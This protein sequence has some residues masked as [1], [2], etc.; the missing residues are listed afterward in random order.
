M[1]KRTKDKN[2]SAEEPKRYGLR[3]RTF[4]KSLINIEGDSVGKK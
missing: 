4:I 1:M 3:F 2:I